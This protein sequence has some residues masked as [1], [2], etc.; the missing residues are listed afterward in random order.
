MLRLFQGP[1]CSRDG[2]RLDGSDDYADIDDWEWG[3]TTSIE[4][5]VKYNSFNNYS[6]VFD[7]SNGGG[8][9]N[10]NLL[11]S[12]ATSTIRW[13]VRKGINGFGSTNKCLD[14]SNFETSTWVHVVVTV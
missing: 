5:Y 12:K 10:V 13:E 4:V 6:R 7:L 9:D 1:T 3:G 14:A 8:S 11:N 2:L